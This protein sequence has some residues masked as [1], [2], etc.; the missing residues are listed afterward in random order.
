MA[1][2]GETSMTSAPL[3]PGQF[4][5]IAAVVLVP[6]HALGQTAGQNEPPNGGGRPTGLPSRIEWT[7]NFDAGWGTFGFANSLFQNPKDGVPE[8][9]SDQWFEGY[10]KP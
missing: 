9:L 1:V 2:T 4:L 5:I 8:N 3:R 10:I 7:F 6:V